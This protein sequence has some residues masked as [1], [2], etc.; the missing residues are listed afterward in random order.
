VAT[1]LQI[2]GAQTFDQ[3]WRDLLECIATK[4]KALQ[5]AA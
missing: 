3:A 2:E 5:A 1:R 4:R